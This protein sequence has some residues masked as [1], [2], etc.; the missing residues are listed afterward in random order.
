MAFIDLA[1]AQPDIG[2]DIELTE[3][4]RVRPRRS[5]LRLDPDQR[6]AIANRVARFYDEDQEARTE[7]ME[8]RL[9]RIAKLRMWT[10]GTNLPWD[11]AS[12]LGL[13]DMMEKS[14]KTQDTLINAVLAT[15]PPI[16][17]K[18]TSEDDAG[19]EEKIDQLIDYQVFVEQDGEA[20]VNELAEAF[21]TDGVFTAFVPWITETRETGR[22]KSFDPIPGNATPAEY[23]ES[24]LRVEFQ[25]DALTPDGRS[26]GWDWRIGEPGDRHRV[27]FYVA[28]D[29]AEV[30]MVEQVDAVVYDGPRILVMDY[31]DVLTPSGTANLQIPGP[32]N[33]G[34]APHVILR[35]RPT[36]DEVRR[37]RDQGIYD[38][39]DDDDMADAA[40]RATRNDA[41][42]DG[43]L[44]LRNVLNGIEPVDPHDKSQRTLTRLTC[45]DIWS[46]EQGGRTEDM[47]WTVILNTKTLVR[48]KRLSEVFPF[49]PP[50]RPLAEAPHIRQRGRREGI[51]NP[52]LVEGLHDAMKAILDSGIDSGDLANSPFFFYRPHGTM[53]PEV[54]RLAKGEGYPL[55][56]PQRDVHFPQISNPTALGFSLNLYTLLNTMG[57][58][59]SAISP[60]E[61]GRVPPGQ[62]TALRTTGNLSQVLAKGEARPERIL[63]NFF[64]G[65]QQIWSLIHEQNR[66]FL[67]ET[68]KIRLIGYQEPGVDPYVEIA[69]RDVS[70]IFR[71]E[72]K[73]N[74]LNTSKQAMQAAMEQMLLSYVNPLMIQLGII[75]PDGIYRLQREYGKSLGGDPDKYLS[76]PTPE[77]DEPRIMA[78]EAIGTA[79]N[80]RAPQGIPME[81]A[82]EHLQKLI[83]FTQSED[84][85]LMPQ[86]GVQLL[87]AWAEQVRARAIQEQQRQQLLAA[88]EQFGQQGQQGV[89]GR[90]PEQIGA[91]EGGAPPVSSGGELI[92]EALPGAGG[93]AN[94]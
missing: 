51:S 59:V 73:A 7:D 54:I 55:G 19:N 74:V 64:G 44:R 39:I 72:F 87:T 57:E 31:E 85:G 11:D 50:R 81:P 18:A 52:E 89:G 20:A 30:E 49:N 78:E 27:S 36:V 90:P 4:R 6:E 24:L 60:L 37:L 88:A 48:A 1:Q 93:G 46:A 9:Q 41:E 42:N 56:D 70:G 92:D 33:P 62:S 26:D 71:F 40:N 68:K 2:R 79:M 53:N 82:A 29:G 67:P 91:P 94:A 61:L 63:R 43:E 23:F 65:L 80:G 14:L 25:G 15:R 32:S 84:F 45:F 5:E 21:E 77:S 83:A 22:F 69:K 47:V 66:V 16:G 38:L 34:G 28:E 35:S 76:P 75:Q 58:R 13:P 10:E 8:N 3:V 17:A 86:V 12:D